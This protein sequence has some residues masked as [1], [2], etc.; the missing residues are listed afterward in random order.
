MKKEELDKLSFEKL[1]SLYGIINEFC[2]EYARMTDGY[3][4]AT[5]DIK[6]EDM[7]IETRKMIEERQML[8]SY[9]NKIKDILKYKIIKIM[10]EDE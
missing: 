1:V 7:P 9:K 8:F 3:S 2:A 6:F 4:L 5:G 10:S